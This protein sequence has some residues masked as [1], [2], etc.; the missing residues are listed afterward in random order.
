VTPDGALPLGSIR[1]PP[2]GRSGRQYPSLD[3]AWIT[4]DPGTGTKA[5]LWVPTSKRTR[6]FVRVADPMDALFDVKRAVLDRN[7]APG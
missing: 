1:R 4:H 7:S 3:S 2:S 6:P 5:D